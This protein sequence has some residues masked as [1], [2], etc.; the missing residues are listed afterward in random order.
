MS[1]KVEIIIG[2]YPNNVSLDLQKDSVSI[3][4][5]YNVADIKK[6]ESKNTNH[7]KTVKLAGTKKNNIAFGNLFDVNSTFDKFNPNNKVSARILVDSSPV[8]EGYVKLKSVS[9]LNNRISYEI[10]VIDNTASFFQLIGDKEVRD[11]DFS[12]SNHFYNKA[13]IEN[14]W[15]NHSFNDV[16]QYPLL[17]KEDGD[18]YTSDFKPA[19][20]HKAILNKITNEAGFNL[21]GSFIT[22]NG[23]YEKELI[24]WDGEEPTITD[25]VALSRE[26]KAGSTTV[27]D[28]LDQQTVIDYSRLG[29]LFTYKNTS[30]N[31]T[32]STG[33]FDNT[34]VYLNTGVWVTAYTGRYNFNMQA[35]VGLDYFGRGE[36]RYI[37]PNGQTRLI[38]DNVNMLKLRAQLVDVNTNTVL[39]E[40]VSDIGY[41]KSFANS[42]P[43]T[44]QATE[45]TEG[46]INISFK[47]VSLLVNQNVTIIL[48]A[49]SEFSGTSDKF[50][51]TTGVFATSTSDFDN[52]ETVTTD[53]YI[54]N[55]LSNGAKSTFSNETVKISS[56]EDGDLLELNLYLPKDIKQKDIFKDLITRYNL[57]CTT[58]PTKSK[59]LVLQTRDDYYNSPTVLNWTQKKDYNTEDNTQFLPELQKKEILLTY[60]DDTS[61]YWS[62]AYNL[63]TGD[64]YGQKKLSFDNDFATGVKKIESIFTSPPLIFK[65]NEGEDVIVPSVSV[66]KGKR[67][68]ALLYW[69]GLIPSKN[70]GGVNS[71]FKIRWGVK[72]EGSNS[73]SVSQT[74]YTTYPYAG[75]WDNPYSPTLDINFDTVTYEYYGVLL[76]SATNNN[77]FNTYW[78]GQT[79]QISTGKLITSKFYL[80]ETDI[81]FIKDNL[82]SRI[83]IKD[84]YYVINKMIDYKPLEDGLTTVELLKMDDVPA[85]V[86]T[87]PSLIN[88]SINDSW[89]DFLNNFTFGWRGI[90][91]SNNVNSSEVSVV[92]RRNYIAEGVTGMINGDNN[93]VGGNSSSI[94]VQGS[95]NTVG[96]G[97]S[98]VSITGDN[99]T[100][101]ESN[102]TV[103]GDVIIQNGLVTST[104]TAT[105]V[106]I[107]IGAW[108]M[109]ATNNVFVTHGLSATEFKTVRNIDVTIL[110]DTNQNLYKLAG[111]DLEGLSL[112]STSFFLERVTGANFDNTNF[113]DA[114]INRGFVK[115]NYTSD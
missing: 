66:D 97:L 79:E 14:A 51:W 74:S 22:S 78:R 26:F 54:K 86:V 67:V 43:L 27:K 69:G 18:Y 16:Y 76:S 52:P 61:N 8:L 30:F 4:L 35:R 72:S 25:S 9:N 29:D 48:K 57:Y 58:H 65:G 36:M 109:D 5:Q 115:Y 107:E 44:A 41:L 108:D 49:F 20:Y 87:N 96:A 1:K 59:T 114:V 15:N 88:Q 42:D 45:T 12:S 71:T 13:T 46:D 19:F 100:V 99:I 7:S 28:I 32:T 39:A 98:N 103:I 64:V 102:T 91:R 34:S 113:N 101:T 55:T 111:K 33:L 93:T 106:E 112:T 90:N 38:S 37:L 62:K 47:D 63:S 68:P 81:N 31:D 24:G 105:E 21:T 53:F 110:D 73:S 75:H 17:N 3:A 95:N 40:D 2:D 83:F 10:I 84:S 92:G 85:L 82:N 104:A 70:S 50:A 23:D 89:K 11:L 94:N 56:I 80:K 6:I 60:K 77:L